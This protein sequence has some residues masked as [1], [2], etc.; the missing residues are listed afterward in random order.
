MTK[1]IKLSI[2]SNTIVPCIV[3]LEELG[4]TVE[5]QTLGEQETWTAKKDGEDFFATDPC[6]LLGLIKLIEMRG[7][8]WQASDEQIDEYFERFYP[9]D[10]G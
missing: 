4:C 9:N 3:T 7:V 2:A 10:A 8:T 5:N 1:K 6:Q